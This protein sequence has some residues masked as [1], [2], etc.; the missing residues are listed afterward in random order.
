MN[1]SS[2]AFPV[3]QQ[4]YTENSNETQFGRGLFPLLSAA[5]SFRPSLLLDP[6]YRRDLLNCIGASG[7]TGR[8]PLVTQPEPVMGVP[9]ELNSRHEQIHHSEPRPNIGDDHIPT[10]Y[11]ASQMD[12]HVEDEMF[13][14]AIR[15]SQQ[16]FEVGSWICK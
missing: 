15:A 7:F 12:N 16:E 9:V 11:N 13:Q 6:N 8:Q 1:P 4:S 3:P 2:T 14:A 10:E 5:R